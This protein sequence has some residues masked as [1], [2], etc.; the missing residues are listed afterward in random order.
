MKDMPYE[1]SI[2]EPIVSIVIPA[3]N[4]EDRIVK[5]LPQIFSY[6]EDSQYTYEIIIVDD[7]STD[8]TVS[9]VRNIV[10]DYSNVKIIQG[11]E[12]RGKGYAV[13]KG[14]LAGTGQYMLFM[15][16]DLS[17]PIEQLGAFIPWL[18][19]G[20][21]ICIASRGLSDSQILQHQPFYREWMGK[22]FNRV[23]RLTLWLPFSDTQCG[24]K[25]FRSEIIQ[26]LVPLLRVDRFGFDVELLYVAKRLGYKIK[27]IGVPWT[28]SSDSKVGLIMDPVK[29]LATI[30]KIYMNRSL[31]R[32]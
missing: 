12:N 31:G 24:F 19:K 16:A 25:C 32:Y 27:E 7:G 22:I 6:F 26:H 1:P 11:V 5:T 4:E 15:D 14:L 17:T 18:E 29:M 23:I 21:D 20:Y 9:V 8:D 28:N 10:K 3:Y 30:P 13:R 2:N